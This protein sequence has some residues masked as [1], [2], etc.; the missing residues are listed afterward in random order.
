MT[1]I[2][3]HLQHY[4]YEKENES[5]DV[6]NTQYRQKAE[7]EWPPHSEWTP[8]IKQVCDNNHT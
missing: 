4:L 6:L 5:L 1:Y 2:K 8:E 3:H 7:H